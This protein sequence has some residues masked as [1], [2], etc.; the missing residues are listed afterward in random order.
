MK[1]RTG[2]SDGVVGVF[3]L[4]G[5]FLRRILPGKSP[6]QIPRKTKEIHGKLPLKKLVRF[7]RS[8]SRK[9]HYGEILLDFR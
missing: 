1:V 8:F 2:I 4:I 9:K 5:V 3:F 7:E 6:R